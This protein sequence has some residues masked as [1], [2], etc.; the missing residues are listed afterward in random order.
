M[1]LLT[2]ITVGS[3][4][5]AMPFILFF[6][7]GLLT[8]LIYVVSH[9]YPWLLKIAQWCAKPANLFSFLILAVVLIILVIVLFMLLRSIL[10]LLL[11][12]PPLLLFIPVDLG[13]I[14]WILRLINWLYAH[15]RGWIVSIYV[16]IRLEIMK[17]KIKIDVQKETDWKSKW[18]DMKNKLSSDADQA[19]G[20]ISRRK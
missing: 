12:F 19:R 10:I 2:L 3:L 20:K 8:F 11:I 4:L 6:F 7:L 18:Q 5:A 1:D 13:L 15:W 9:V 14:V 17:A 16:S